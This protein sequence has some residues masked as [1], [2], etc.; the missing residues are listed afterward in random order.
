MTV[1]KKVWGDNRVVE[2]MTRVGSLSRKEGPPEPSELAVVCCQ[3]TRL[4]AMVEST[5]F[6][7]AGG[8]RW[9]DDVRN[10]CGLHCCPAQETKW[11]GLVSQLFFF[12]LAMPTARGSSWSMD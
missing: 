10:T 12:F 9:A 3:L 1:P 2:I 11:D 5:T 8:W 6:M 7:T 4:W